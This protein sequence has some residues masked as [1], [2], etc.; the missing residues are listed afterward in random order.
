MYACPA[1]ANKSISFFRKWLSYPAV[2]AYCKNCR[3]FSFAHRNSGGVGLV[4]SVLSLTL[5]GFLAAALKSTLPLWIGCSCVACYY[6]WHWHI[7]KLEL[8]PNELVAA[9]RKTEASF[10]ITWLLLVFFN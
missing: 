9:A 10:G 7:V 1:C 8:I 4:V 3:A 5:I 2:P 6:F